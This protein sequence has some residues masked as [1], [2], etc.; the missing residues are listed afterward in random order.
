MPGVVDRDRGLLAVMARLRDLDRL[1]A[2]VGILEAA[3][4][5]QTT[6]D[7]GEVLTVAAVAAV[8]E[9]GSVNVPERSFLRA[10]LDEG[11]ATIADGITTLTGRV[12][13]G[14]AP[15][16]AVGRLGLLGQR[17]V[18]RK[19]T[20]GPFTPLAERTILEKGSSRPLIDTGQMRRAV[21]FEVVE[22]DG[23]SAAVQVG[24]GS[25]A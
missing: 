15:R 9:F 23:R 11:R 6:G 14:M 5:H 1:G 10:G 20:D 2:K 22:S 13:D 21:T 24:G 18:Q 12:V 8:H 4:N 19:L 7:S 3:G 17:E 25:A 16:V